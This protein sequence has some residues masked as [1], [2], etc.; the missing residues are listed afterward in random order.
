MKQAVI[1][2][3]CAIVSVTT[4][5][6]EAQDKAANKEEVKKEE[7][8][9]EA[10]AEEATRLFPKKEFYTKEEVLALQKVINQKSTK[11]EEDIETQKQYMESLN[12]QVSEHLDKIE[13]ARKEIAEFMNMRDEKEEK[14]LK[15]LAK[16]YEAMEP[17]SA[18][19]LLKTV[20]DELMIK[21]FDRMDTKKAGGIL[22][23]FPAQRAA[24]IT[25]Q[26][27]KLKLQADSLRDDGRR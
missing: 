23:Q 4:F 13:A 16:F 6:V 1:A 21:I 26:F 20:Q 5:S 25:A 22:A 27:P 12:K 10:S 9:T 24:R 3:I 2:G 18:A 19:P 14:K 8:S 17:E 15:K 11:L 7:A